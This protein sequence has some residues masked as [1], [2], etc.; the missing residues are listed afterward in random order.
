MESLR[1]HANGIEFAALADGP[2]N[3]PLVVLLHGFPELSRS[4]RHQLPALAAAGY[5]SVAP[6]LRGYGETE[7][8]GPYDL[9]TLTGDVV[10]LVHALGRERATLV[11]HDWGGVIGWSAA[12][13][14][15]DLVDRL[16]AING[17]PLPALSAEVLR[18]PRQA[19]R[20]RYIAA[21]MIPR[22][23]ERRLTRD[24]ASAIAR[25]IRGGSH[26]REAW[27]REEL[28][29]YRAAF[30]TKESAAAALA[31][32]R[33]AVRHARAERREAARS[34]IAAPVLILWGARDRFVG[35]RTVSPERLRPYLAPGNVPEL[36]V[37]DDAG[38][39]L[40][41]EAPDWVNRELLRWLDAYH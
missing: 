11:A 39:F 5:R 36:R 2:E 18:N 16:V 13:R 6:D 34:P 3:G 31:Y 33:T 17:P 24:G 8:R 38:H 7:R 14:H 15:P 21:F 26:V 20:S 25:A 12:A 19:R 1:L 30:A 37:H 23:P 10:G 35:L 4:W 41:N 28:D 22:L 32:Y 40:Q 9:P 27:P 29:H